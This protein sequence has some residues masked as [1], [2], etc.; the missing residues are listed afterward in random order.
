MPSWLGRAVSNSPLRD[1]PYRHSYL[2]T[3]SGCAASASK[4][5]VAADFSRSIRRLGLC[6]AR[7][8]G[9]GTARSCATGR[10]RWA[11]SAIAVRPQGRTPLTVRSS[12]DGSSRAVLGQDIC[13]SKAKPSE[14]RRLTGLGQRFLR[15][16]LDLAYAGS[17]PGLPIS[18]AANRSSGAA[19]GSPVSVGYHAYAARQQRQ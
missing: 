15:N 17:P 5:T 6:R 12:T 8:S 18:S 11:S 14:L 3:K 4:P 19:I 1:P 13:T 2:P 10:L 9:Q 7:Q 16:P